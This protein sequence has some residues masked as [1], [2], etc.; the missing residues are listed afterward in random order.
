MAR[1]SNIFLR[2]ENTE[3]VYIYVAPEDPADIIS[4]DE[5]GDTITG[6]L[7]T[8]SDITGNGTSTN[9]FATLKKALENAN[10]YRMVNGADIVIEM[11]GGTYRF[12]WNID[13]SIDTM[14]LKVHHEIGM[15]GGGSCIF[16]RPKERN[17]VFDRVDIVFIGS[18]VDEDNIRRGIVCWDIYCNCVISKLNFKW[19][20]SV[21]VGPHAAGYGTAVASAMSTLTESTKP[22]FWLICC[23]SGWLQINSCKFYD[24]PYCAVRTHDTYGPTKLSIIGTEFDNS[25]LCNKSGLY[26]WGAIYTT[27]FSFVES[28]RNTIISH[29]NYGMF[30]HGGFI[31]ISPTGSSAANRLTITNCPTAPIY[32]SPYVQGLFTYTPRDSFAFSNNGNNNLVKVGEGD[33][34]DDEKIVD[35]TEF[36]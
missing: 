21:N 17:N 18:P 4:V 14:R 28:I 26:G 6:S 27:P 29:Y 35:N 22:N 33:S 32:V 36:E 1:E 10:M 30:F 16:I 9:P 12:E 34:I 24:I 19:V 11:Y 3:N 5:N 20:P 31:Q 13:D 7:P 23:R 8:G 2:K 15:I 25:N